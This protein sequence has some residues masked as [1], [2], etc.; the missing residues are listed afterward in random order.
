MKKTSSRGRFDLGH[1]LLRGRIEDKIPS[2]DRLTNV[3]RDL[4]AL[5]QQ[6]M[7]LPH[8]KLGKA[9]GSRQHLAFQRGDQLIVASHRSVESLGQGRKPRTQAN[10]ALIELVA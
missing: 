2:S 5:F 3:G 8:S 6:P 1:S 7:G 9:T 4:F 10:H